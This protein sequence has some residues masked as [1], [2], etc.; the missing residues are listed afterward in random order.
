MNILLIYLFIGLIFSAINFARGE[1]QGFKLV[2]MCIVL[3]LF[4]LPIVI[5]VILEV[6]KQKKAQENF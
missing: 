6:R 2:I 3:W 5:W 4:W 1:I